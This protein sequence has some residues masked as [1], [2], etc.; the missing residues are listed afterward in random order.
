M[1]GEMDEAETDNKE[2]TNVRGVIWKDLVW[3]ADV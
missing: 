3:L 1:S 2:M